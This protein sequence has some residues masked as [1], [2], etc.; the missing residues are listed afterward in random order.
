MSE[1][2]IVVGLRG[3][4]LTVC[5]AFFAQTLALGRAFQLATTLAQYAVNS[6]PAEETM[7]DGSTHFTFLDNGQATVKVVRR[8]IGDSLPSQRD[9]INF[10]KG[11][12]G[13][14]DV[15]K[16]VM[17]FLEGLSDTDDAPKDVVPSDDSLPSITMNPSAW[18]QPIAQA[19]IHLPP[20]DFMDP[21]LPVGWFHNGKPAFMSDL[22][23]SPFDVKDPLWDLTD[24]Q[25]WALIEVRVRESPGFHRLP[26]GILDHTEALAALRDK[27]P[28]GVML[29]DEEIEALHALREDL[30]AGKKNSLPSDDDDKISLPNY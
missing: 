27:T 24:A 1:I 21:T 17:S 29:K 23:A 14:G 18:V 13:L 5:E 10:L 9:S 16:L 11:L 8:E 25:K 20:Y 30:M 12:S 6:S 7:A 22:L 26:I 2:Y 3:D 28:H 4:A 15:P 19:P